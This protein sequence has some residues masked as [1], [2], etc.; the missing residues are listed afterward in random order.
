MG[1]YAQWVDQ[2]EMDMAERAANVVDRILEEHHVEPLAADIQRDVHAV[3]ERELRR[4]GA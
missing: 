2:G 4:M 3:V 1:T